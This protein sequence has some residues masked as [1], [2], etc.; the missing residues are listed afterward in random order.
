MYIEF[1]IRF[2]IFKNIYYMILLYFIV[3]IAVH[4]S[5]LYLL[6]S[7]PIVHRTV[8]EGRERAFVQVLISCHLNAA[9]SIGPTQII[10]CI[11]T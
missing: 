8:I 3:C 4:L 5:H 1:M 10:H 6:P 2:K 11:L 9:P 7:I